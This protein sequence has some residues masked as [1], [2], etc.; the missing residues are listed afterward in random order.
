MTRTTPCITTPQPATHELFSEDRVQSGPKA[1]ST[2][3]VANVRNVNDQNTAVQTDMN[4][5]CVLCDRY[6][7]SNKALEQHRNDSPAHKKSIRCETCD[8]F[9]GSREALEQHKE[10]S[11]VHKKPFCCQT[12]WKDERVNYCSILLMAGL[13]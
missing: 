2:L 4:C 10:N 8:R 1:I 11:P 6:F 9:F 13:G 7:G 3:S 5:W 12:C